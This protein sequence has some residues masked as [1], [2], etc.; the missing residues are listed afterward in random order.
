[1][2][3]GV[4]FVCIRHGLTEQAQRGEISVVCGLMLECELVCGRKLGWV[5]AGYEGNGPG[6]W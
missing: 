5:S 1:M 2:A 4:G 3:E 6:G